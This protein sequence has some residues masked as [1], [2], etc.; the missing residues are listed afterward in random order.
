MMQ[1]K[2]IKYPLFILVGFFAII[3]LLVFVNIVFG[4]WL[5]GYDIHIINKAEMSK[6]VPP[7]PFDPGEPLPPISQTYPADL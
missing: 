6:R 1:R 7:I 4:V 3:G 2:I 5:W